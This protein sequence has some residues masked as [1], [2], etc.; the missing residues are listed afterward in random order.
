MLTPRLNRHI[1]SS[2]SCCSQQWTLWVITKWNVCQKYNISIPRS[3]VSLKSKKE[4]LAS[5]EDFRNHLSNNIV[6]YSWCEDSLGESG[7][8][9]HTVQAS[10][11]S[12]LL[13]RK[14]KQNED[15]QLSN[16]NA[17]TSNIKILRSW[18]TDD[19]IKKDGHV[20]NASNEQRTEDLTISTNE[21]TSQSKKKLH[22]PICNYTS[23]NTSHM[24]T[25]MRTH[26]GEKP[27][28][29]TQCDYICS[30]QSTL[31]T[32]KRTHTGEKPYSCTQCDYSSATS[33]ALKYHMRRH[34]GEKPYSCTQCYYSCVNS[35]YLTKHMRTHTGEKPYSCSHC[36]F[37]SSSSS[38]LKRHMR[39]HEARW[40]TLQLFT[41]W[42]L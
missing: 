13:S 28:S 1:Y 8:K 16:Q 10:S 15:L 27:Y 42:L 17:S 9:R 21:V 19:F 7:N 3:C 22:C 38:N 35:T 20:V 2:G 24:K 34:T 23:H 32:H 5:Y 40:R 26:T 6:Q 31:K 37:S 11:D 18:T 30:D 41:V 36:D 33:Q 29:C 4:N 25:H 12:D 14:A 39:T